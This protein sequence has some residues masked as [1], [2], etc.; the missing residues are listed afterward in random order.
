[1]PFVLPVLLLF[2]LVGSLYEQRQLFFQLTPLKA[3]RLIYQDNPFLESQ[4][5]AQYIRDHS[6]PD[7]QVAVVGSE[8]QI[9]FYSNRH[10]ATGYIYTYALMEAQPY[11]SLMQKEMIKEI[12]TAKPEFLVQVTYQYSWLRLQSSDLTIF[13]WVGHYVD[14]FYMPIAEI[15]RQSDGQIVSAFGADM[16]KISDSLQEAVMLYQRKP[17]LN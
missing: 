4:L 17:D 7:A 14:Q 10:S 2:V 3:S 5:V 15:G 1:M 11:A 16:L 13:H 8:P 9:Y 6:K 12:E